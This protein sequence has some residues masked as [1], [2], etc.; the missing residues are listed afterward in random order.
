MNDN[1]SRILETDKLARLR[2]EEAKKKALEDRKTVETESALLKEK[3]NKEMQDEIKKF[4]EE[5]EKEILIKKEKINTEN[6]TVCKNLE[7]QFAKNHKKWVKE[8]V[9]RTISE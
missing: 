8:I 9:E 3:Y 2:L 1:I 6:E 7:E 4:R 5:K